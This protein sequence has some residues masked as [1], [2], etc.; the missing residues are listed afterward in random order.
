M[1]DKRYKE[2]ECVECKRTGEVTRHHALL[3]KTFACFECHNKGMKGHGM[4]R[5]KG[6]R[7]SPVP[8]E[9]YDRIQEANMK[10]L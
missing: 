8:R 7:K 9:E 10:N 3:H 1:K 5:S 4:L 2:V 6:F